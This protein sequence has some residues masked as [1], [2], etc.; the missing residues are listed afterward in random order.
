MEASLSDTNPPVL[1]RLSL[2]FFPAGPPKRPSNRTGTPC[3]HSPPSSDLSLA[4]A[5]ESIFSVGEQGER[6]EAQS[7]QRQ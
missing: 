7:G 4:V 6:G 2:T 3:L 5:E 1:F